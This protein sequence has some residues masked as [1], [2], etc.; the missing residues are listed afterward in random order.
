VNKTEIVEIRISLL[1]YLCVSLSAPFCAVNVRYIDMG[2]PLSVGHNRFS[3]V[4]IVGARAT[5]FI[6]GP[7]LWATTSMEW[8]GVERSR[9]EHTGCITSSNEL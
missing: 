5:H 1:T 6:K 8:K 3:V 9:V 4:G 7:R 2:L